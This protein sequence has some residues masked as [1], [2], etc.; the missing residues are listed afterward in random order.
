MGELARGKEKV[1][2]IKLGRLGGRDRDRER[3]SEREGKRQ[4]KRLR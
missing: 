2:D 3:E 4:S 1:T